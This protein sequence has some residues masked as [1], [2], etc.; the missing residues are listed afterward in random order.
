MS[1]AKNLKVF[2]GKDLPGIATGLKLVENTTEQ[3]IKRQERYNSRVAA[4]NSILKD[5]Q[6]AFQ[7]IIRQNKELYEISHNMQTESNV[8]WRQFTKMY[9]EAY[10]AARQMNSEI[11][12]QLF[13]AKDLIS[14]QDKL[15]GSGWKGLDPSTLNKCFFCC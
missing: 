3:V 1:K 13:T 9:D 6:S 11:G 7:T 14:A 2:L 10:R 8:T 4:L 15:L 12:K 5:I